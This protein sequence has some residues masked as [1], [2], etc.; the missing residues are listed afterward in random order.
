MKGAAVRVGGLLV[1]D[2]DALNSTLQVT[3]QVQTA[4]AAPPVLMSY[5]ASAHVFK[6]TFELSGIEMCAWGQADRGL[7]S[8]P[9]ERRYLPTRAL[10]GAA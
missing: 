2:P 7:L 6:A 3:L 5:M 8:I 4:L 1:T 10:Q 9:G